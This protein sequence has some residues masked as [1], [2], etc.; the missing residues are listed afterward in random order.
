MRAALLL[1]LLTV[2]FRLGLELYYSYG[3]SSVSLPE[4]RKCHAEPIAVRHLR[5]AE[6]D[7]F[8]IAVVRRVDR[9]KLDRRNLS[10]LV[11][12]KGQ[13]RWQNCHALPP[14]GLDWF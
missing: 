11:A 3:L 10:Y 2:V 12:D 13:H 1:T 7:V 8:G 9:Y 14:T 5:L 6:E 4:F